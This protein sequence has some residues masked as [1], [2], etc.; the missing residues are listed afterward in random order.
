VRLIAIIIAPFF[1]GSAV[2]A[3]WKEHENADVL[4]CGVERDI[5]GQVPPAS[6]TACNSGRVAPAYVPSR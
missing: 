2:A 6:S 5:H 4:R 3:D 1:A